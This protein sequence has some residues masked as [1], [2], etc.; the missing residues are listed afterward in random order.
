MASGQEIANWQAGMA[1]RLI[2]A[3]PR[4]RAAIF[5]EYRILS[6]KSLSQLYRIAGKLGFRSGRKKRKDAGKLKCDLSDQQ[7]E[8]VAGYIHETSRKV[9]GSIMP[10][11]RALQ[12]AERN[13]GL[14]KDQ[15]TVETMNRILKDRKL[16]KKHLATEDAHIGQRTLHPNHVHQ[17]DPSICIQYYLKDGTVGLVKMKEEEF[18]KNKPENFLKIK[19]RLYRYVIIDHYSGA[20]FIYYYDAK[21]ENQLNLFDFLQRAWRDKGDERYP[22]RGV[23]SMLMMDAGSANKSGAVRAMLERLDVQIPPTMP[24][25][26]RAR[27]AVEGFHNQWEGAFES[28]LGLQPAYDIETLNEWAL[29]FAIWYNAERIHT[30]HK[31]TRTECWIQ[32]T[33]EQLREV[34]DPAIMQNLFAKPA[35]SCPVNGRYFIRFK[36]NDYNLKHIPG[37]YRKAKVNAILKPWIHPVIAVEYQGQRYEA[38]PVQIVDGGFT[39]FDAVIGEEFKASPETVIQQAKKRIENAA[40]GEGGRK[41]DAIPYSGTEAFGFLADEVG[42]RAYLPRKGH[43][44][45]VDREIGETL[46]PVM[47]LIKLVAGALGEVSPEL[48]R[49]IKAECGDQVKTGEMQELQER[50]ERLGRLLETDHGEANQ[51]EAV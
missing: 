25:N 35:E 28:G 39:E 47:E 30:R 14:D 12:I 32:I 31:M 42:N 49:R 6:G 44:I 2:A 50:Y 17:F 19:T 1:D 48:N 3:A 26:A 15:V 7:V 27:G 21:G 33:T 40:F 41:K 34:P 45:E 38:K 10:T 23:P 29:D 36:G 8:L 5:E 16:S 24:S 9:K 51:Q 13:G 11:W 43:T 46:V 37:I 20:F 22:F 4:A 18:N